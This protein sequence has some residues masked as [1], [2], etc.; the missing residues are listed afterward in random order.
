MTPEGINTPMEENAQN[1]EI[2]SEKGVMPSEET[3][4][5]FAESQVSQEEVLAMGKDISIENPADEPNHTDADHESEAHDD[6]TEGVFHE[7]EEAKKQAA[8]DENNRLKALTVEELLGAMQGFVKE[9]NPGVLN[10][11]F[12]LHQREALRKIQ[13]TEAEAKQSFLENGGTE[14]HFVF[15]SKDLDVLNQTTKDFRAQYDVFIAKKLQD[16]EKNLEERR[17]IIE[18]LKKLYT[19]P[20]IGTNYFKEIRAI[21]DA[22]RNAGQVNKNNY[23]LLNEDYYFHLGQF[24]EMLALNRE[25]LEQEYAHNLQTRRSLIEAARKLQDEPLIQKALNDLQFLHKTWKEEAEPVAE[26]F[27]ES[28]WEEFKEISNKIHDRKAEL[29]VEQEAEREANY[30]RKEEIIKAISAL[31]PAENANHNDWQNALKKIQELREEFFGITRVPRAKSEDQWQRFKNLLKGITSEKNKFYKDQ[32]ASFQKNIDEKQRLIDLAKA[33]QNPE[34]WDTAV[35]LFKQMQ[36]DW[37]NSGAVPRSLSNK[38]WFEFKDLCN[39]FFENFRQAKSEGG[40]NW[41]E[42]L[43]KKTALLERLST[44]ESGDADVLKSIQAEWDGIGKVPRE[45]TSINTEFRQKINAKAKEWGITMPKAAQQSQNLSAHDA[46][47]RLK[48]QISE[49]EMKISNLENNLNFFSNPT[50]ENPLLADTYAKLDED[51]KKMDAYKAELKELI[52]ASR[53][54][55]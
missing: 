36:N 32:K 7:S 11:T 21:K 40:D 55:E 51:R 34:N 29:N 41:K 35:Q 1:P 2:Q 42:N 13:E 37:K 6:E 28:T 33:N 25:Y 44:L 20:E 5:P 23:K 39:T 24:N 15:E 53:N 8:E 4:A 16:Q 38:L 26:E 50:R 52:I 46:V 14:E 48:T 22:W 31:K 43:S 30:Q 45:N 18:R 10:S 19:N 3:S 49:L 54:E 9:N 17:Q 12:F 27:R 47:K